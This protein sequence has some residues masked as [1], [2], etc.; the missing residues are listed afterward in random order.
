MLLVR[1][2]NVVISTA[3]QISVQS[4]TLGAFYRVNLKYAIV[5]SANSSVWFFKKLCWVID[6]KICNWLSLVNATSVKRMY[7]KLLVSNIF[8]YVC[9]WYK[10]AELNFVIFAPVSKHIFTTFKFL[11]VDFYISVYNWICSKNLLNILF[12]IDLTAVFKCSRQLL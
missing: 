10:I 1:K 3:D 12:W 11:K 4:F 7:K 2:I 5:S 8:V 9:E 6:V